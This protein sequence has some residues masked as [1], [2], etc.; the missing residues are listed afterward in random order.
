MRAVADRE[1]GEIMDLIERDGDIVDD[2]A[3]ARAEFVDAAFHWCIPHDPHS[4]NQKNARGQRVS[5]P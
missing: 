5:L 3:V 1:R 4:Q 2:N